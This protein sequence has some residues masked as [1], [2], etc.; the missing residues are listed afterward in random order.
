MTTPALHT[1]DTPQAIRALVD[2]GLGEIVVRASDTTVTTVE[3]LP[4]REGR[5]SD[6]EQAEGTTVTFAN[7][8]LE[9]KTPKQRFFGLLG[10][11][12][13]I[14]VTVDLPSG[15]DVE[16]TTAIGD[17]TIDGT[18]ARCRVKTHAGDVRIDDVDVL[19]AHASAGDVSVR[20][21]GEKS[22][23]QSHAGEVRV[24]AVEGSARV[25]SSAGEVVIGTVTGDLNATAPYGT[26]RV[27]RAVSGSLTLTTSF[28]DIEVGIPEGTAA[29]LDVS[30]DYGKVRNELT[31]TDTPLESLQRITVEGRTSYGSITIRRP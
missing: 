1:F 21:A 31:P 22:S 5:K 4:T 15:S 7:G 17:I 6:I 14:T 30:S 12:G 9:I 19:E 3:V 18:L 26:I 2:L 20:R 8:R 10:R 25:K 28:A 16:A 23:I 29:R 27:R 11:P 24:D 13:G